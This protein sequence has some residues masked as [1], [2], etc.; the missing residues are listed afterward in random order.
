[1]DSNIFVPAK[2]Y[3]LV[4]VGAYGGMGKALVRQCA[5]LGINVIGLDREQ[6]R[7]QGSEL[8]THEFFPCDVSDEASVKS[9]FAEIA[10]KHG[11]IDGLINLAGYT[12]ERIPV[13]EM[14]TAEWDGIMNTSV[15]G[16]FFIARESIPLLKASA[17]EG[18]KPSMILVSSTFGV[19]VPHVGY[20][21]YATAKAGVINLI[22]ALAT[23]LAPSIRVNGIAPGV[24]DTPFLSGGTGRNTKETRLDMERFMA[25]IPVQRLGQPEEIGLPALFLLS[26]AASYITGQTI[27]VN[28]GTYMAA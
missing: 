27:H 5:A 6:A 9:V 18:N 4:I 22:R 13:A 19:R 16:M 8:P 25:T 15:R 14:S 11:A 17:A 2:G 3:R 28:G 10:G 7:A 24:I 1:M 23:E 12:G 21:P 20:A 26:D